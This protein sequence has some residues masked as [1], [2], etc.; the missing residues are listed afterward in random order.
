MATCYC[1]CQAASERC[2]RI[3]YSF[4]SSWA[5]PAAPAALPST[6][7]LCAYAWLPTS[8]QLRTSVAEHIQSP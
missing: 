1:Q 6:P 8:L 3:Y 7:A 5:P 4:P 2:W